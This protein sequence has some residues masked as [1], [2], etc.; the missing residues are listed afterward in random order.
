MKMLDAAAR[1]VMERC[2]L[3]A[4]YSE[5]ADCLTRRYA[6]VPLRQANDV[7]ASWMLAAGMTVHHDYIGNVIGRYE[8]QASNA[9]T[10][11]FGSHLDTVCAAGKYDGI[12]GVLVPLACVERLHKQ[13]RRLPFAI[14]V[15]GFADEEGVRYHTAYL[16]SRA[17]AGTFD[18]AILRYLDDDGI[19]MA[20]AIRSFGGQPDPALL[21]TARWR[22]EAL[23]G[24]CEVHIEQGPVL[25][26]HDLPIGV[27]SSI[28]GQHRYMLHFSGQAGHAGTVP[29][30]MRHDALCA[31][32]EYILAVEALACQTSGLV[33]TVGKLR[34][35]P[36]ASNV[37]PGYVS[38]SLD[39]RHQ[40][41]E[42][43]ARVSTELRQQALRIGRE[44]GV[45]VDWHAVQQNKTVPCSPYLSSLVRRAIEEESI[46]VYSLASG[47][48]HDA[49]AMSDLTEV[50]MLFVRCKGGI[51]HHADESVRTEDVA[52]SIRIVDRLLDHLCSMGG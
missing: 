4:R 29:M 33:A 27:V 34:V 16:G 15:L 24:Y 28:S 23:L 36:G 19:S 3:L 22:P 41:D 45:T 2:D 8:G 21:Q 7:V 30:A 51:S 25:E 43:L 14:E 11:L 13:G 9:R 5:D 6:T 26:A 32:S 52:V 44:R 35:S 10:M 48:G 50:A 31:A 20:D 40:D 1:T 42:V 37:I 49:V 47:A 17:V 39:V 38:A 18:P 12:L 46:P